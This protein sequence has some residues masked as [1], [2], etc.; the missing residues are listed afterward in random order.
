M[1]IDIEKRTIVTGQDLVQWAQSVF[2]RHLKAG[3]QVSIIPK[4]TDLQ[5]GD[6][7]LS[8]V[9]EDVA[10]SGKSAED[11]LPYLD[12]FGDCAHIHADL[13]VSAAITAGALVVDQDRGDI[14][15]YFC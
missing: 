12:F 9:K 1:L 5:Q 2:E 4:E 15:V 6:S 13:V 10:R 7:F 11:L 14:W 8:I 3:V